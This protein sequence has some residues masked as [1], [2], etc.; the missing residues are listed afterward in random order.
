MFVIQ[1]L[2][3]LVK[4]KLQIENVILVFVIALC[5]SRLIRIKDILFGLFVLLLHN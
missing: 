5:N 1:V 3:T 2:I 4:L